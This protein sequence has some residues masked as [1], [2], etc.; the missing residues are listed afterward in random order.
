MT[1]IRYMSTD[2]LRQRKAQLEAIHPHD[3]RQLR[4][5]K[6]V[7]AQLGRNLAAWEAM[8]RERGLS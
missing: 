4:S 5:W 8:K 3:Y 2:E 6:M 1:A 7:N